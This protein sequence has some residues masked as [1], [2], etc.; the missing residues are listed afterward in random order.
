MV[1]TN[2]KQYFLRNVHKVLKS[3]VGKFL[4]PFLDPGSGYE[5]DLWDWDSY[6]TAKALIEAFYVCS[7]EEMK[8]AG[9][10]NHFIAF[11]LIY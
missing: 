11:C 1:D 9:C 10:S 2:I 8:K 7:D 5:G 6:F 3:P 4:Y